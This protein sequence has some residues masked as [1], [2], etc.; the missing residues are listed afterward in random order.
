VDGS[1]NAAIGSAQWPNERANYAHPPAWKVSGWDYP[2]GINANLS[3]SNSGSTILFTYVAPPGL[4]SGHGLSAGQIVTFYGQQDNISATSGLPLTSTNVLPSAL[5]QGTPYYVISAGLTTT[6][7]EVS[8]TNGGSAISASTSGMLGTGFYFLRD[9]FS[10]WT[11]YTTGTLVTALTT[12][13][14]AY[15]G[16]HAGNGQAIEFSGTPANNAV[17][18]GYDF[19]LHNGIQVIVTD[20]NGF[21]V[22]DNYSL[23]GSGA[24]NYSALGVWVPGTDSISQSLVA[25]NV[26]IEYNNI[27]CGGLQGIAVPGG[28]TGLALNGYGANLIQ[29]NWIKNSW[30]EAIV[31]SQDTLAQTGI[32]IEIHFNLIEMC[33][34]GTIDGAHGDWI[35]IFNQNAAVIQNIDISYNLFRQPAI[36]GTYAGAATQGLSVVSAGTNDGSAVT[37]TTNNNTM[38]TLGTNTVSYPFFIDTSSIQTTMTYSNNYVDMTGVEYGWGAVYDEGTGTYNPTVVTAGNINMKT[39]AILT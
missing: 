13:G 32:T 1:P 2:V 19:S 10:S 22:R 27:D 7:F 15:P 33:G 12:I 36:T 8:T 25:T 6:Q 11:D 26:T 34:V 28:T 3:M 16:A 38:V 37:V 18:W 9:P 17:L 4:P 24:V 30:N 20:C 31:Y 29:Y 14:G 39:G 23:G 35:Q 5:T 21:T